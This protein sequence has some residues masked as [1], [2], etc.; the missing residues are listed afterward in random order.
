M[1]DGQTIDILVRQATKGQ[2]DALGQLARS[3]EGRVSAYICRVTL[4]HALTEDLTQ[5][6]LLTMV[7]SLGDLKDPDRF[8]PWLYRIAQSKIQQ[9]YRSKQRHPTAPQSRLYEELVARRAD[10]QEHDG[11]NRLIH[12]DLVKKTLGAMRL[13]SEQHRA[14]LALRCFD[15]LS[16]GD[17][18]LTMN[19]TEVKAR[20]LFYRAKEALKKQ[21]TRQGVRK[22][23]LLMCLGLFGKV[24]APADA[25]PAAVS[26]TAASMKA[27]LI[28]AFVANLTIKTALV[29]VGVATLGAATA[30]T[31]STLSKTPTPPR[32]QITSMHFTTQLRF[33][34]P[35]APASLSKGAYEQWFGFPEGI[36][37]PV[38]FRMQRWDPQKRKKLC[39][40]LQNGEANYYFES[41]AKKLYLTN[42][43]VYWSCLDVRRLP[44]D[45]AE[46][47]AFLSQ[48]EGAHPKIKYRRDRRSGLLVSAV[49]N[50]FADARHFRTTYEYNSVDPSLFTLDW[51]RGTPI[52]DQRDEMHR[53]GW[54]YFTVRGRL[55]DCPVSGRGRVPFVYDASRQYPAWLMLEAGET[56]II[57]CPEGARV[58]NTARQTVGFYPGGSFFT[59]LARPWMGLHCVDTIRRD[60][61]KQRITFETSKSKDGLVT[62]TLNHAA[63]QTVVGVSYALDMDADLIDEIRFAINR[64]PAGA[65]TFSYLRKVDDVADQFAEPEPPAQ[66]RARMKESPGL[67][68]LIDLALGELGR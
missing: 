9:H 22:S 45:D 36:D 49:D 30:Q 29:V 19:C 25:A 58:E 8:W 42:D 37:G 7:S 5:E 1:A 62:V 39:A 68:W 4:S 60:A 61:V 59:G 17:I 13:L 56:R 23:M 40:W 46:F 41:G 66:R 18:A 14:V 21:L 20:V 31:V 12:K 32:Q 28:A 44:T 67:M 24:T 51:P 48:V 26:V 53:R 47:T 6:V 10:R 33:T 38:F 52:V 11:L 63:S 15:E 50:R 57:D 16:Y 54:T 65:L 55:G 34:D 3:V 2:R 64:R 35:S 43:R 27:G